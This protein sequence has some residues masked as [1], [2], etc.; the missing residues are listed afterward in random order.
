VLWIK[1]RDMNNREAKSVEIKGT[2]CD[3]RVREQKMWRGGEM[4]YVRH[5]G[6]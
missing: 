1:R 2:L 5:Q 3:S 4:E 6:V